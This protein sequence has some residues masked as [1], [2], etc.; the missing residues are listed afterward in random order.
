MN[1]SANQKKKAKKNNQKNKSKN[2]NNNKR[3]SNRNQKKSQNQNKGRK[4]KS[5]KNKRNSGKSKQR[6]VRVYGDYHCKYC[7]VRW[8]S[9]STYQSKDRKILYS[10]ECL[11]CGSEVYAYYVHDLCSGCNDYPCQWKCYYH[12]DCLK[13]NCPATNRVYGYYQC[14]KCNKTWE[15]A[16]TWIKTATGYIVH[17]QQCK[18]CKLENIAYDCRALEG[19]GRSQESHIKE[20]CGKCKNKRYSCDGSS[21]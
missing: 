17:G 8:S 16:Y 2:K 7:N 11:E 20:L 13:C 9:T 18:R 5:N 12:N 10:Q 15:S 21:R 6:L 19:N 3:G 4:S 1:Q 14:R